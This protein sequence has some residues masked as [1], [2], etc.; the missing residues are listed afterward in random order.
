MRAARSRVRV[1][2]ALA[3]AMALVL[4][5]CASN[6]DP[7]A[8]G[9]AAAATGS[10]NPATASGSSSPPTAGAVEVSDT[11]FEGTTP[12]DGVTRP[13]PQIPAGARCELAIWRVDLAGDRTF[14]LAASY[15]LTEPNTNGIRGGGTKV[16]MAGTWAEAGG[17][18]RLLADDPALSI[19]FLRVGDTVLHLIDRDGRLA[20]GDGGWSYTLNATDNAGSSRLVTATHDEPGTP[21]GGVFEGRTPCA[22]QLKAFTENLVP[23][24]SRLTWR[25]T[26]RQDAAGEPAGYVSGVPGR[27]GSTTGMWRIARGLPGHPDAVVYRLR[28]KGGEDELALLLLGGRHLFILGAGSELLGGNGLWSYT[29]SRTD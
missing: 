11:A 16:A 21:G 14:E 27:A 12:C 29:L 6:G 28:P 23:D 20:G 7:V 3:A 24:C 4:S 17:V 5:G 22:E 25:L 1:L 13:L 26:F 19:S 15:G 9:P 10:P 2:L 8:A 18:L